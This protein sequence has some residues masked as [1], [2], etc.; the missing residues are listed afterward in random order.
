MSW[1]WDNCLRYREMFFAGLLVSFET[2]RVV[3]AAP[4]VMFARCILNQIGAAVTCARSFHCAVA[5]DLRLESQASEIC[6]L[7]VVC[8][9]LQ[10]EEVTVNSRFSL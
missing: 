9:G 6:V 8:F 5:A 2:T 10:I 1:I 3:Q 7:F 4:N